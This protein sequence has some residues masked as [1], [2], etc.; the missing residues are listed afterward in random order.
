[1]TPSGATPKLVSGFTLI[2]LIVAIAIFLIITMIVTYNYN[3]FNAG[4]IVTNTAYDVALG[5]RQAQVYGVSAKNTTLNFTNF[6][7]VPY[8]I[9]FDLGS[10]NKFTLFSDENSNFIYDSAAS[11]SSNLNADPDVEDLAFTSNYKISDLC[12]LVSGTYSCGA[13]GGGFSTLDVSFLRPDPDAHFRTCTNDSSCSPCADDV[14]CSAARIF[15][16][17][18]SG[19]EKMITV[20]STGQISVENPPAGG[21]TAP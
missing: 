1:M 10:N 18:P 16:L 2:E 9:H 6:H 8:G 13:S 3:A 19:E 5:I 20:N 14:T 15:I 21:H 7:P 12:V 11:G 17:A 4:L